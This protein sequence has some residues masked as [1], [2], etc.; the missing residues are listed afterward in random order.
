VV[1]KVVARRRGRLGLGEDVRLGRGWPTGRQGRRRRHRLGRVGIALRRQ[2][3]EHDV[4]TEPS[5]GERK[6]LPDAHIRFVLLS[7]KPWGMP[8]AHDPYH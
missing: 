5:K 6:V 7:R 8:F 3:I 2:D 4:A 1:R